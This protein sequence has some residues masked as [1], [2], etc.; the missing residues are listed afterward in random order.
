M[1]GE[2]AQVKTGFQNDVATSEA[3]MDERV[4]GGGQRE[5]DHVKRE[6]K[7]K[8]EMVGDPHH[9]PLIFTYAYAKT[10]VVAKKNYLVGRYSLIKM[11]GTMDVAFSDRA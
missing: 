3:E 5:N 10:S 6:R 11:A 1:T 8:R 2:S 4:E 7:K 9:P